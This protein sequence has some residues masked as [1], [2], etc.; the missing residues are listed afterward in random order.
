MKLSVGAHVTIPIRMVDSRLET[1]RWRRGR[2]IR[3]AVLLALGLAASVAAQEY[4]FRSYAAAEGLQNLVVLSL[5]QDR[6]G[7]IWVG[8]EGGLY[9]YDG[10][11]FQ[12][13]GVTQ[14]LPCSSETHG[15]YL[16][17][18][19]ALW[20]NTCSGIFRYNGQR[21]EAI[22]GVDTMLRGAQVMADDAQGG[23]LIAAPTGLYDA[24]R[25]DSGVF[26]IHAYPLPP[27]LAGKPMNGILRQGGRLWFGCDQR[28]CMEEAGRVSVFGPG[29]GLP[30]DRW[31][32]IQISPD[33]SV[34][35]RSMKIVY[36]RPPGQT[37]FSQENPAIA[38]SGFWGALTLGRDGSVMVPTDKGLAIHK[39]AGWSLINRG[40][41]LHNEM[42][43]AVLEDREGSVW[44]GLVGYGM[45]RWVGRGVWES[46]KVD[47]GLPSDLVWA[48]RRDRKGALWVGT[49]LGLARLDEAKGTATRVWSRKDGLGGD[50]VRWL[51]E[52]SDGSI[53]AATKP[54]GLARIDPPSGKITLAGKA[55]GLPCGP[56]DVFVDRGDRLWIPTSCGVFRNDRPAV[57]DRFTQVASPESL[58]RGTWKVLED[59]QGTMWFT[60][61]EALW[62][63]RDGKW[64]KY[65]RADGLLTD[66]PYVM[67]LA[68]D[69][70]IWLRHRYDAGV[71]RV[72]VSG[73]RIVRSTAVVPWDPTSGKVTAFH[74]FDAYG[75]FWR[76]GADGATV[77]H[78]NSW[79]AFTTEDGLVS[80]ICAGEA[81]WADTDGSVWLGTG[82]G[83]SHY[84]PGNKGPLV[85]LAASPIISRLDLN[86]ETRTV[87]A[88]FSSLNY[89]AE[90]LVQF[91]Y[92]L[93]TGH[94]TDSV[95][96][97]ISIAGMGP[98]THTL[99]VRCR[100]RDDPYSP[101]IAT[102]RFRVEP[103]WWE[104]WW[105]R[106]LA[107]ALGAG[108]IGFFLWWRL[109]VAARRQE[110]MMAKQKLESLGVLTAGIAHDF[111]N[112]LGSILGQAELAA[113]EIAEGSFPREEIHAIQTVAIRAAEVVREL[114]IY[115]GQD[116]GALGE[117]DVSPLVEEMLEL[118]KVSISKHAVV[119][120]DLAKDLPVILGNATQIRQIM[121]NLVLNASEAIGEKPGLITVTTARQPNPG[122]P[123]FVR[124]EV[125][126]T[127]HGITEEAQRKIFEPFFTTRFAGRGLGLSV[128][129]GIVRAHGGTIHLTSAPGKGA[130]L[131]ILLPSTVKLPKQEQR[132]ARRAT[133]TQTP[134][135][136]GTVLLVEDEEVLRSSVAEMLGKR[137][138]SVIQAAD[139]SSAIDRIAATEQIDLILLDMTIPGASGREV[140]LE[141]VRV[142]PH[143][144]IILTSAYSRETVTQALHAPQIRGFIRKPFRL[145]DLVQLLLD[146]LPE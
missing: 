79:T 6:A 43:A 22:P 99:E 77:R 129:Q 21:F 144:R 13:I 112:F 145:N 36:V 45:A 8:T 101:E 88:E 49:G 59:A 60:N 5:A 118:L 72:E 137:G 18:D 58:N 134:G 123:D 76:C 16:A 64:R 136:V 131:V 2:S 70:S 127:G 80:N 124:L 57:S 142:H 12:L 73:D 85:P 4:S 122:A 146:T 132:D 47:Q 98:G 24:S 82:G 125:S 29:E 61:R 23:L 143:V 20:V 128:V 38:S 14:G 139:G 10:T 91:A 117:V 121:M 65:S 71:E 15:L 25:G 52:T 84:R 95:E 69:G 93:D 92:R 3:T 106:L 97:S 96:R 55:E 56:E 126:D 27:A 109:R 42:T 11:R 7:Y 104:T 46:W 103:R 130:T 107:L 113:S 83:L 1:R 108:A 67:T 105:A 63:L 39:A 78:G 102:S 44:I 40:R 140:I 37:M 87:R 141:A 9:R 89:K 66:H 120:T 86:E 111:N 48:I 110:E 34:W 81:F 75:N 74:G 53:W 100:V 119:K 135:E 28:L 114:M 68:A 35:V 115:A 62:S 50:N 94:W 26:S 30:P 31:D 19:G 17:S 133:R 90:Q 138:F 41:G 33:G 32:G 51:A 116:K 54:G